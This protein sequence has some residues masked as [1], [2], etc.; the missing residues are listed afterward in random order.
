[1]QP[2]GLRLR[3]IF[4]IDMKEARKRKNEHDQNLARIAFLNIAFNPPE[5]TRFDNS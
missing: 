3:K 5:F 2:I 1:M 4:N